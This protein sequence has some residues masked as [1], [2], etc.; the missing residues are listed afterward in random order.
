[1]GLIE[2]CLLN[3]SASFGTDVKF[4]FSLALVTSPIDERFWHSETQSARSAIWTSRERN[5]TQTLLWAISRN[6]W[7]VLPRCTW[8][9]ADRPRC[10]KKRGYPYVVSTQTILFSSITTVFYDCLVWFIAW[11]IVNCRYSRKGRTACHRLVCVL[12]VYRP[13]CMQGVIQGP[14]CKD[15]V[16]WCHESLD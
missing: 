10:E 14:I 13:S 7:S 4:N 6:W 15:N 1:M 8:N 11:M 12:L 3:S 2:I 5:P 16:T 9:K